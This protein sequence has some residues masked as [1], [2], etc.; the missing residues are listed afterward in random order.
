[1]S[2]SLQGHVVLRA[3]GISGHFGYSK[4]I[5]RIIFTLFG[6]QISVFILHTLDDRRLRR[7][8]GGILNLRSLFERIAEYNL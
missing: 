8:G 5:Y 4:L 1:M 3:D 2:R 6:P 7:A